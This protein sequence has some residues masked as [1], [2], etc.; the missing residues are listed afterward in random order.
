MKSCIFSES[1]HHTQNSFESV[2]F[3]MCMLALYVDNCL[4]LAIN[5]LMLVVVVVTT[6]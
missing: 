3:L 2:L 4:M 6:E 1:V 5:N